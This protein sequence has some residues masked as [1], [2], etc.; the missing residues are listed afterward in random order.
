MLYVKHAK[1]GEEESEGPGGRFEKSKR[2]VR[3]P[4]GIVLDNSQGP[5]A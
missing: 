4:S 3:A 1:V 5:T 2:K